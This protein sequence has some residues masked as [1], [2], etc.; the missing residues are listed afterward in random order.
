MT[1][2]TKPEVQHTA[3]LDNKLITTTH[4]SKDGTFHCHLSLLD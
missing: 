4:G 1:S 2:T 3:G